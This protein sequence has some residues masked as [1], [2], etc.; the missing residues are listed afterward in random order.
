MFILVTV[1]SINSLA[2][3]E[4]SSAST[5]QYFNFAVNVVARLYGNL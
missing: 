2:F 1:G 4:R 5:N 3:P